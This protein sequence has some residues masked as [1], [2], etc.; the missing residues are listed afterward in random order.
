MNR[1]YTGSSGYTGLDRT[2]VKAKIVVSD[3]KTVCGLIIFPDNY[4]HPYGAPELVKIHHGASTKWTLADGQAKCADNTL[5]LEQWQAIED[6]GCA[7]LPFTSTTQFSSAYTILTDY[8]AEAWYWSATPVGGTKTVP[9]TVVF[10]DIEETAG[11]R[12]YST[13][14]TTLSA[15]YNGVSRAYGCGVRLTRWVKN[16]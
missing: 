14:I 4:S 1:R 2:A 9:Y 10:N 6:A 7:F 13:S 12:R 11:H 5:T 8:V 16:E 15:T 3:E